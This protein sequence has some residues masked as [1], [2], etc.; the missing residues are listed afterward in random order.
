MNI[1]EKLKNTLK[2]TKEQF[3]KIFLSDNLEELEEALLSADIGT[4]L[5]QKLI[6]KCKK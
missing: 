4:Q 6:E 3:K 2:K 5:T 1:F